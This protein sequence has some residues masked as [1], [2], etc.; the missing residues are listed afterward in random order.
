M[1]KVLALVIVVMLLTAMAPVA[2][3][4][5]A[6]VYVS[7]NVDGKLV[8]AAQPVKV[9]TLTADSVLKAAH[10]AYYSG[11]E[12]GYQAGVDSMWNMFL[13]SKCW[14]VD[15]TPYVIVNDKPIGADAGDPT[16]DQYPVKDGDNI[17]VAISSDPMNKPAKAVALTASV[18]GDSATI[19]A[20]NW[21]LDFMTFTY[22]SSPLANAKVIDPVSGDSL[23]T[24]DAKGS[25]KVTI[26][27]SGII[28]IDGLSAISVGAP[29]AAADPAPAADEP[30]PA[31]PDKPAAP[32]EEAAPPAAGE[33]APAADADADAAAAPDALPKTDG[34]ATTTMV[35]G[36]ILIFA[37]AFMVVMRKVRLSKSS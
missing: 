6:T 1:K 7:V 4:A 3:A 25:A 15:G 30:A 11:G 22:Q 34:I 19:T 31:A 27:Q 20:T 36:L 8:L 37:G 23:G 28:A 14:G 26:P 35:L 5:E 29:A 32:A 2:L 10:K 16:V 17:V 13:I 9:S 12:S 21:E 18:S 24:T 33:P